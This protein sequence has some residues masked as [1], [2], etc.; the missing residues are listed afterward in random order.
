[1]R[2][3]DGSIC[4]DCENFEHTCPSWGEDGGCCEEYCYCGDEEIKDHFN[5]NF[6]EEIVECKYFKEG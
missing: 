4:S 2:I 1:M 5:Y 6:D 3:N